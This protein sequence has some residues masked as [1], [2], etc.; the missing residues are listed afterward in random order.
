MNV[1][2]VEGSSWRN[3]CSSNTREPYK[4]S[5]G[6]DGSRVTYKKRAWQADTLVC[7]QHV[8][9][10][11]KRLQILFCAKHLLSRTK[12]Y[13]SDCLRKVYHISEV[14][15]EVRCLQESCCSAQ[16]KTS[17]SAEDKR[18]HFRSVLSG[19]HASHVSAHLDEEESESVEVQLMFANRWFHHA[20]RVRANSV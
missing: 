5:N 10:G 12:S 3:R 8:R 18:P 6:T 1:C 17:C 20:H 15:D 7:L 14:K 2:S 4:Y 11:V 19:F 13:L 9:E 16:E